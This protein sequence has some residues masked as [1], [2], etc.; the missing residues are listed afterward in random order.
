MDV[1]QVHFHRNNPKTKKM[2][3]IKRF[4]SFAKDNAKEYLVNKQ[5]KE[6]IIALGF[7]VMPD[8]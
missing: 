1:R 4:M 6:P 5:S 2:I 8:F 7:W 3:L